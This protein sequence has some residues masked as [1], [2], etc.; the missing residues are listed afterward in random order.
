M[1]AHIVNL[2]YTIISTN[3]YIY[4]SCN[5]QFGTMKK[6]I[7]HSLSNRLE[8]VTTYITN[9]VFIKKFEIQCSFSILLAAVLC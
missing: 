3:N 8:F 5:D 6:Q 4:I 2:Q 9:S 1:Y 7:R